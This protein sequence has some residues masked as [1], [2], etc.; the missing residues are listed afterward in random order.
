MGK[1]TLSNP[2]HRRE[3]K[4]TGVR[5]A[6]SDLGIAPDRGAAYLGGVDKAAGAAPL[7][8]GGG[9]GRQNS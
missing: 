3:E 7:E 8:G 1:G 2:G 6:S 9:G 5:R 4:G